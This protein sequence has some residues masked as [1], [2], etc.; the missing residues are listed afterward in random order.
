MGTINMKKTIIALSMI[1]ALAG[2]AINQQNDS[3]PKEYIEV[4]QKKGLP[5]PDSGVQLVPQASFKVKGWQ[6]QQYLAED[7][8]M[9]EKGYINRNSERA[10]DLLNLPEVM[11]KR[12]IQQAKYFKGTDSHLRTNPQDIPFAYTFVGVPLDVMEEFYG[13]APIG[14]YVTREPKG[15]TG[16][17][18]FFKSSFAYCSYSEN[19]MKAARGAARIAQEQASYDVNGKITLIDV[20]GNESSGFLYHVNWYDDIFIRDVE[21]ASR[22]FSK[23]TLLNTIDLAQKIDKA[24]F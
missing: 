24:Y 1:P 6:A 18:E 14:T 11:K 21:C 19:N 22:E 3:I 13:I 17:I 4:L 16:A 15:W 20:E 2:A 12:K 8:E 5:T 7:K 9:K 10:Y 23:K